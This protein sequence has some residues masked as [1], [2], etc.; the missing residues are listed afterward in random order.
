[1]ADRFRSG[2][3]RLSGSRAAPSLLGGGLE[4]Q[5]LATAIAA[6]GLKMEALSKPEM[7]RFGGARADYLDARCALATN[8]RAARAAAS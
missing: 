1:M 3:R 4:V 5:P 7:L 6:A 2:L 8:P